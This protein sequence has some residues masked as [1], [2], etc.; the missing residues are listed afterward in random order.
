MPAQQSRP[1]VL[2]R[3]NI[4]FVYRPQVEQEEPHGMTDVQR[5]YI[6]LSP[7]GKEIL[8]LIL[9]GRKKLPEIQDGGV[10]YWGFVDRIAQEPQEI[11]D[12]LGREEYQ[13]KTR[14]E[15]TRPP[16]RPAGEGVY[17]I[18]RHGNHNHLAYALELPETPGEV[19]KDLNIEPEGSYV[20]SVKN[21]QQPSPPGAGLDEER[22]VDFPKELQE[23]FH[24]RRFLPAEP[25][26]LDHEGAEVLLIGAREDP[27]QELGLNLNPQEED[28]HKAEVCRELKMCRGEFEARPLF[29]GEWH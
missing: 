15:R 20:F 29:E 11:R 14:G 17:A 9:L 10:K 1:D 21:P 5:S 13:T 23:K 18:V 24:G 4:Y 25:D 28:Q 3:G 27:E 22:K 2:E 16:A 19:Q 26:L 12:E 6:V 8:R 7:H